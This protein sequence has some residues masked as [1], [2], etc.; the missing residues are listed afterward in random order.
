MNESFKYEEKNIVRNE[1]STPDLFSWE[2]GPLRSLRLG[3]RKG[4]GC[5][6]Y[7]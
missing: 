4:F 6:F 2:K 1:V 3:V 7:L 5:V